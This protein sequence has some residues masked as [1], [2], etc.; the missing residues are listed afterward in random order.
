MKAE[1]SRPTKE[2]QERQARQALG[3]EGRLFGKI[4][5]KADAAYG[6]TGDRQSR[7]IVGSL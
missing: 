7:E 5:T 3:S 2:R 6:G 4:Q 1:A